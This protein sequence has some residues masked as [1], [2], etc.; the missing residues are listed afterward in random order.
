MTLI[1]GW[2][3]GSGLVPLVRLLIRSG[4]SGWLRIW[5]DQWRA[6]PTAATPPSVEFRRV[7][8]TCST[9]SSNSNDVGAIR[10]SRECLLPIPVGARAES[11]SPSATFHSGLPDWLVRP[12]NTT[13]AGQA[14]RDG[15][16]LPPLVRVATSRG[17]PLRQKLQSLMAGLRL[18]SWQSLSI[19]LPR[20]VRIPRARPHEAAVVFATLVICLIVLLPVLGAE[21]TYG[22]DS[23]E[24][25]TGWLNSAGQGSVP[26]GLN[27]VERHPAQLPFRTS[28]SSDSAP[29][30]PQV[31]IALGER[32]N[33]DG[34]KLAANATL[35][36]ASATGGD[37][38]FVASRP[39]RAA[40]L[41]RASW[42][43][44]SSTTGAA[45][46]GEQSSARV[47]DSV[48]H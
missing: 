19:R 7:D 35:D 9:L 41:P 13:E 10:R 25:R 28:S 34:G 26:A 2:S 42:M 24:N 5:H 46:Q 44:S 16:R 21:E 14:V 38:A 37:P 15:S 18:G 32:L 11:A 1:H 43:R 30:A 40:P 36:Q 31:A 3:S 48:Y 45:G 47:A 33:A 12:R 8:A 20:S 39:G 17:L 23:I 29:A 27:A 6:E 4:K 22:L